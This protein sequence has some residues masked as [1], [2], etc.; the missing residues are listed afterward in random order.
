MPHEVQNRKAEDQGRSD[1]Y[2]QVK[3]TSQSRY[4][5]IVSRAVHVYE[6]LSDPS[7]YSISGA[8]N[9]QLNKPFKTTVWAL[10]NLQ[11]SKQAQSTQC[12]SVEVFDICESEYLNQ[13]L[14]ISQDYDDGISSYGSHC[15]NY[16][17]RKSYNFYSSILSMPSTNS[18]KLSQVSSKLKQEFDEKKYVSFI[19]VQGKVEREDTEST[20]IS[21]GTGISKITSIRQ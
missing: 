11:S 12:K 15:G 16:R 7:K 6:K 3:G 18:S 5:S 2:A 1:G 20:N 17:P 19:I 8:V 21:R 14:L 10:L 4:F 13:K 9:I